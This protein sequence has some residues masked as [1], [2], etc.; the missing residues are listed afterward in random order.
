MSKFWTQCCPGQHKPS[1]L[2]ALTMNIYNVINNISFAVKHYLEFS[3]NETKEIR[4]NEK[5]ISVIYIVPKRVK[6]TSNTGFSTGQ[7]FCHKRGGCID[8]IESS[9]I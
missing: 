6:E 1:N 2:L 9:C 8:N 7:Q 5:L 3:R 4:L